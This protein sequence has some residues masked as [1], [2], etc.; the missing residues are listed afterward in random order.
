MVGLQQFAEGALLSVL[1][2][3]E[4]LS[5]ALLTVPVSLPPVQSSGHIFI[6]VSGGLNCDRSKTWRKTH[7]AWGN[8]KP[9]QPSVRN[10]WR[11]CW[12]GLTS[13]AALGSGGTVGQDSPGSVGAELRDACGSALAQGWRWARSRGTQTT[14]SSAQRKISLCRA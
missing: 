6:R 2:F 1:G 4:Q 7:I 12:Q 10:T 14:L 5:K 13:C 11:S 8:R 9:S 3:K